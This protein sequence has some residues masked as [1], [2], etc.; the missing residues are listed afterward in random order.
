MF[1]SGSGATGGPLASPRSRYR[2]AKGRIGGGCRWLPAFLLVLGVAGGILSNCQ[3]AFVDVPAAAAQPGS[4]GNCHR[5]ESER[6]VFHS[7][8]WINLHHFLFQW[9]R[10]VSPRQ[11]GDRR[12][13]VEVSEQAQL[14]DL[15]EGEQQAWERAVDFYRER[16][17]ARDLLVRSKPHRSQGTVGGDRMFWARPGEHRY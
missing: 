6:F 5:V 8:P 12:R 4:D 13:A 15:E 17:I 11:S 1:F 7:D 3:H 2:D 14:G 16:L 10:D 9:A